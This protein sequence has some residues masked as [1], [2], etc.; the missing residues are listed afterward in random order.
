MNEDELLRK[1]LK[2]SRGW[3]D[4]Y[5]ELVMSHDEDKKYE[6]NSPG[7]K[8]WKV[9]NAIENTR[10]TIKIEIETYWKLHPVKFI[11]NFIAIASLPFLI[12]HFLGLI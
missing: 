10:E 9:H 5:I 2:V 12:S 4:H 3:N 7:F 8:L 11:R 1:Y 6:S